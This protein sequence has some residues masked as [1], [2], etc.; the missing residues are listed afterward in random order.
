MVSRQGQNDIQPLDRCPYKGAYSPAS[1]KLQQAH[2]FIQ[3]QSLRMQFVKL[4]HRADHI[5]G[6]AFLSASAC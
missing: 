6:L 2:P 1:A 3:P 5:A 4:R